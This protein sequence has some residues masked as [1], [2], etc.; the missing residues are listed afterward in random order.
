M[1]EGGD[2]TTKGLVKGM[3]ALANRFT[4]EITMGDSR[5]LN[6]NYG[7]D[8]EDG[9]YLYSS[10]LSRSRGCCWKDLCVSG[11]SWT[12]ELLNCSAK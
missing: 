11:I 6:G 7:D 1:S 5:Q 3:F 10:T 2:L 4:H 9:P 8:D 12:G